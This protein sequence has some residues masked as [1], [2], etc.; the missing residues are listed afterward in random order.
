ML[1]YFA[2]KG[3]VSEMFRQS[4]EHRVGSYELDYSSS[5]NFL[6]VGGFSN[7]GLRNNMCSGHDYDHVCKH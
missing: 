3:N 4:G 1:E 6:S 7:L 2:G 5:M